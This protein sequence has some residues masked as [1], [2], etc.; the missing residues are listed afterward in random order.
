[1]VSRLGRMITAIWWW[2]TMWML[3]LLC[4][5]LWVG[6]VCVTRAWRDDDWENPRWAR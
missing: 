5:L 3:I 1:M 4:Y 2:P 6:V